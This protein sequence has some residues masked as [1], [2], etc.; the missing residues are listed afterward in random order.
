MSNNVQPGTDTSDFATPQTGNARAISTPNAN[1][2]GKFPTPF[3]ARRSNMPQPNDFSA[4]SVPIHQNTNDQ[5]PMLDNMMENIQI[6]GNNEIPN[7]ED[8][9]TSHFVHHLNTTSNENDDL[10]NQNFGDEH[11]LTYEQICAELNITPRNP[12]P[13]YFPDDL[14]LPERAES[15]CSDHPKEPFPKST[16]VI[17]Y[18]LL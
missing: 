18:L 6:D 3:S 14:P 16:K 17:I 15:E 8:A 12:R 7:I 4:D 5:T 1:F 10:I 11:Y 9:H 2:R 13:V